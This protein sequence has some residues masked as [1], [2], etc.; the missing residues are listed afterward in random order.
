MPTFANADELYACLRPTF[1]RVAEGDPAAFDGL[2]K[3]RLLI[4]FKT[5]GPSAEISLDGRQ[6]PVQLSYGMMST[7]ADLEAELP[8]DV[9]H[10]IL[11][12]QLSIKQAMA[13]GQIRVR[14]PAWKL[15]VVIDVIKAG[16]RFYPEIVKQHQGA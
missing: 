11:L 4:R 14:G 16:R 13:K 7:R 3:G 12:D 1:G 10:L 9:L 6:R 2:M 5:S 15:A 8:A